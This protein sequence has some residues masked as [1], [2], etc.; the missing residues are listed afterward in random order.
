MRIGP[1]CR[2]F[3]GKSNKRP[4]RRK[5]LVIAL[6]VVPALSF[7]ALCH[8]SHFPKSSHAESERV[9]S[10]FSDSWAA[11]WLMTGGQNTDGVVYPY[12]VIPGG[13]HNK[14]ELQNA[15]QHDVLAAA[16]Y[17][18]FQVA[19]VNVIR[20]PASRQAYLS[21]RLGNRIYWTHKRVTLRKGETLLSDGRHLARTRCGNRISD[22]PGPTSPN[23]PPGEI[24][25]RPVRPSL[26][27]WAPVDVPAGP[28]APYDPVIFLLTLNSAAPGVP[29]DDY[30][31]IFSPLPCCG[32]GAPPGAKSPPAATA[33]RGSCYP[34]AIQS[35]SHRRCFT[36]AVLPAY[37]LALVILNPTFKF[38]SSL[39]A[40][41][42]VARK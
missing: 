6:L 17:S 35:R 9:S 37:L 10:R 30:P 23:E 8:A 24:F 41:A 12:S 20:L 42:R 4:L 11:T 28:L 29:G 34:G 22:T 2:V 33:C 5:F 26:P 21:Y 36:R 3:S 39:Q 31:P 7:W 1:I 25:D 15:V 38:F 27:A 18:D 40:E 16:H 13:A 32:G 19:S 14:A